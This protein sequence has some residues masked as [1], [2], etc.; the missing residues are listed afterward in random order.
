MSL[1]SSP[2]SQPALSSW[3]FSAPDLTE[4]SPIA[5]IE[6]DSQLRVRSWNPRAEEMFGWSQEEVLGKS[7]GQ[8]VRPFVFEQDEPRAMQA[9]Q[10]LSTGQEQWNLSRHRNY[11]RDGTLVHCEWYSYALRDGAGQLLCILSQVVD[12]TARDRTLAQ[13]EESERRFKATFE[14]AAVGI[15]H[16]NMDGRYLRA[17][18]RLCEILGYTPQ[19]MLKLKFQ[20]VTHP[21]DLAGDLERVQEM[22]RGCFLT[23]SS[24]K[25]YIRKSGE[26]V[27][28]TL[29]VSL[30]RK[31]DGRPDYFI[32]VVE[33]ISRRHTV[34]LE[35]DALLAR[36]LQARTEAEQLVRHRSAELAATRSALVQAERL[37]T[38]GQ[39]AA[40]VGHEINNPLA[41]VLANVMYAVDELGLVKTPTPGV[42]LQEVLRALVQARLGAERIRDIVRDLRTFARGDPE[43]MGPVDVES[44]LEFS[45][46][47]AAHEIRQRAQ[48]VRCYGAVPYVRGNESRLGQ[49]FLNLLLNAAQ[50]IPEGAAETHRVMVTT[51]QVREGWVAIE[52]SDTGLGILPEN[53]P[54]IFEPFFTTK[55]VGLGTGLGL[56]VCHGI[57]TGLGGRIEVES[58][59]GRGTTFRVLLPVE[60]P[61]DEGQGAG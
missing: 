43:S 36:E 8:G 35:R 61:P 6:W 25:R 5:I 15:A 37:A 45:I 9:V 55:P 18:A 39:L 58:Q 34:E 44:V 29:T 40:G 28:C 4:S 27:W 51:R 47:M 7:P 31:P 10:R 54:H 60:G 41:Y 53:V 32:S 16:V 50:A 17:N 12:V 14:L 52:V 46:A 1:L 11:R 26:D 22:L 24:E 56:S 3:S 42:D 2:A 33:D 49:V 38:A 57:V 20:E 23:Y 21:D 30:V 13:L 48:L 19:E 59:P